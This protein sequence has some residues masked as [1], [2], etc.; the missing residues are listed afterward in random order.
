MCERTQN[1]SSP[2]TQGVLVRGHA[3]H[4]MNKLSRVQVGLA[5]LSVQGQ[6]A[7]EESTRILKARPRATKTP[8]GFSQLL[9]VQR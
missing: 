3:S 9:F 7:L 8:G 1:P 4:W 2:E 5:D 6:V